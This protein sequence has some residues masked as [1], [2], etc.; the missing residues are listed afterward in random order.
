[1]SIR[2]FLLISTND[3]MQKN[4]LDISYHSHQKI[5]YIPTYEKNYCTEKY[6]V[7]C[8]MTIKIKKVGMPRK[9]HQ[10]IP[11]IKKSDWSFCISTSLFWGSSWRYGM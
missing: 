6:Y 8:V 1:M 7:I 2:Y 3:S 9:L 4:F 10:D 5:H 11:Y